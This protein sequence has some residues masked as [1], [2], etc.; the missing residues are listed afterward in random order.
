M[1]KIE[2]GKMKLA[3]DI[4]N[5]REVLMNLES[6]L[7]TKFEERS[8]QLN[9]DI[10]LHNTFFICDQVRINQVLV[11]LLSNAVKYSSD[12]SSI[13]LIVLETPIDEN[14][15][16]VYFAVK[17][18]GSGIE[19]EKQEMIFQSFEQ[20]DNS[21]LERSQGTGLGLAISSRI[22]HM[23]DSEIL[24]ESTP[25]EG[26]TF[27]FTL[28]LNVHH[29]ETDNSGTDESTASFRGKRILV[30]EDNELNMEIAHTLLNGFDLEVEEACNGEQAVQLVMQSEPGYFDLILM[31][32][33]MPVMN[34]YEATRAIRKSGR[35]DCQTIPIIAMSANAFE[36]D[37]KQSLACGMNRHIAKP[38]TIQKLRQVLE[39][40]LKES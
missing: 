25:G 37:V 31:D 28:R 10:S 4:C 30:V 21:A 38:V 22:I 8:I 23:M 34:G 5:L 27:S 26:S 7:G 32:I 19:K 17:D 40:E 13:S 35:A 12:D 18:H 39:E 33:M 14:V 11:N 1:S 16:D 2:S 20:A 6:V 36:E 29:E 15:S 3:S 9:R 24:V